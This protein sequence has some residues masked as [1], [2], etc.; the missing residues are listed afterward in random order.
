MSLL[1]IHRL[2]ESYDSDSYTQS[3]YM[4]EGKTQHR[5]DGF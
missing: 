2:S 1:S 5:E 4:E 3:Y